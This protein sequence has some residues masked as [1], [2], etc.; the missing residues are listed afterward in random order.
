MKKI[1]ILASALLVSIAHAQE[2]PQA[3]INTEFGFGRFQQLC[4]TCHGN[5]AFERAPSPAQLR[6]MSPERIY[7][8]LTNGAMRPVVGE[9]LTDTERRG[10]AESIAGHLIGAAGAG[11]ADAMPNRC[12]R[13]RPVSLPAR[14]PGWNGWSPDRANTRF[15][16]AR[17]AR[18]STAEIPR[19]KLK[20]AFGYPGGS[21]SA[22]AQPT[23]AAGRVFVGTDIGYVYSLDAAT[24]CVHWSFRTKAAVRA[25]I[26]LGPIKGHAGAR[27]AAYV[28]DLK[29]NVY[30][31]DAT[32][33]R[34]LWE[35]KVD[36]NYTARVTAAPSLHEGRLFV[37]VSSWEEFSARSLDYP[38]CT[39]VGSVV[40]LDASS[41]KQIWKTYVI[42]ERPKPSRKNAKGVQQWAPAGGSVWNSPTID[43]RRGALYVGTGDGTTY[44][45]ADTTDSVLALD[46]KTGKKLWHYQ[47]HSMDSFLVACGPGPER[48]ENCPTVQGPDWD[49]PSSPILQTRSDGQRM[50]VVGTKPGDVLALDPDDNGKV[51]WR[52]SVSGGAPL[53]T[54]SPHI[55]FE[56]GKSPEV[57]G[58]RP[59]NQPGLIWGGASDVSRV[60]YGVT[61]GGVAAL[62]LETGQREWFTPLATAKGATVDNSAPVSAIPGAVFV[63]GTDGVLRA[64]STSDGQLLWSF[65]TA[66]DFDTVNKVTAHGGSISSAGATV[67]DG[68]VFVPSGYAIIGS[69]FGNV[70][71]AFAPE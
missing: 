20:W 14:Q 49:I 5:P 21:T 8:S 19:L 2:P 6:D 28:G 32:T 33:G 24:G 27:V 66:R 70:L 10:I 44:P 15:Q 43:A 16:A 51:L 11:E 1:A 54:A 4:F 35:T 65:A 69:Q 61:T 42:D 30:A 22:Y 60:Y 36:E 71:L 26:S 56:T 59:E 9:K 62:R 48:T 31:L 67:A 39:S 37:P 17:S 41:G 64:L 50:I 23:V 58:R 13:G 12:V 25:A 55:K 34:L 63:G 68:M 45:P 7:E 29:S 52:V 57:V 53:G 38:C 40:A 46:L 47:V 3:A 18:L